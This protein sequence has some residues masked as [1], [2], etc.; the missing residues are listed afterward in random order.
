MYRYILLH[1]I[2]EDKKTRLDLILILL[3]LYTKYIP[4]NTASILMTVLKASST[5]IY[6][7][8]VIVVTIRQTMK[9]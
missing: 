5:Q 2:C 1:N 4:N 9:G 6:H 8:L 3:L 7:V